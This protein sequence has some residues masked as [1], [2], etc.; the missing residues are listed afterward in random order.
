MNRI[1]VVLAVTLFTALSV[2]AE[3]YTW[4]DN[5]GVVSFT[6][7]PTLIPPKYRDKAKKADDITIRNLK[8]QQELK[9]QQER[10]RQE[11][12]NQPRINPTPDDVP[13]PIQP[14]VAEPRNPAT[15]ELPPGR[16]K[17]ER[18]RENIERRGTE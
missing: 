6:D 10:A 17:S 16:T 2:N 12:L 1:T 18:I 3:T 13:K 8:V 9:D 14:P 11:E 15:D 7:D 5:K 4:T